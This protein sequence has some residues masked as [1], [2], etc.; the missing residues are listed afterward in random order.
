MIILI[1]MPAFTMYIYEKYTHIYIYIMC[2]FVYVCACVCA[3][4]LQ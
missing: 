1:Y 3:K 2:V 4:L